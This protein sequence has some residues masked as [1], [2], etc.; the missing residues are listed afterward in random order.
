M[1]IAIWIGVSSV[2]G[3]GARQQFDLKLLLDSV[4]YNN[5]VMVF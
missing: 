2:A 4:I 5:Q 3:V 1:R